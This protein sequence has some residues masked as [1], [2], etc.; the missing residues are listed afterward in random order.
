MKIDHFNR[1]RLAAIVLAL[2]ASTGARANTTDVMSSALGGAGVYDATTNLTWLSNANINGLMT[3]SAANT[4]AAGLVVDGV[5]GWSLPTSDTCSGYNCT[6]SQMG[7]LFYN[8]LG[9][10]AGQSITT[11]HTSNYN[12]FSNFR[13]D[14]YWS[15]TEYAPNTGYAW[16]FF[17]YD[18]NQ[19]ANGKYSN[20]Y[21]LAVRPGL[22][23]AVP[24]PAAAW[25]FGSGLL[26]LVGVS[27]RRLAL[28]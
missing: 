24:L 8:A 12:L 27:R 19:S 5:S 18:G 16:D 28:R 10:T 26:G 15:G 9:G 3:W 11:T 6:G 7:N 2:V 20:M 17:F 14:F 22:V 1:I 13:S 23:A 21:A 4:W 25:L